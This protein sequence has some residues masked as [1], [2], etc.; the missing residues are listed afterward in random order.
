LPFQFTSLQGALSGFIISVTVNGT[1]VA[2]DNFEL[3]PSW[4]QN[5][6]ASEAATYGVTVISPLASSAI[7]N[8]NVR[9]TYF[10]LPNGGSAVL[11]GLAARGFNSL[12][13]SYPLESF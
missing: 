2:G 4:Y 1:T 8:T 13:P 6:Y 3:Y 7:A 10:N 9:P 12:S 5:L 11:N